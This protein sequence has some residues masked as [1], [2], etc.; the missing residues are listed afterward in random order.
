MLDSVTDELGGNARRIL[1]MLL[2]GEKSE[3]DEVR[4]GGGKGMFN[5]SSTV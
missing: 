1:L 2:M 5:A 3:S 4:E